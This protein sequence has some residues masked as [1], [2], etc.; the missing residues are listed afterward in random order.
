MFVEQDILEHRFPH[1]RAGMGTHEAL[2]AAQAFQAG[3]RE[4]LVGCCT[5]ED[6]V[7]LRDRL[8][9]GLELFRLDPFPVR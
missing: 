2:T 7:M 9:S 6:G 8:G 4:M 3:W 1:I 5:V